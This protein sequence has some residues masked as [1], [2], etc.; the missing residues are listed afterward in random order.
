MLLSSCDWDDPTINITNNSEVILTDIEYGVIGSMKYIDTL[1]IGQ[2]HNSKILFNQKVKGDGAYILTFKK[3]GV[4][5]EEAFG[6]YTNSAS[7]NWQ[8]S[9][10]IKPDTI[11]Y[12]Y[13]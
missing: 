9:V 13:H 8:I 3:K 2:E 4:L 1:L 12:N 10:N 7:L 5:Y 11:I 6:Y